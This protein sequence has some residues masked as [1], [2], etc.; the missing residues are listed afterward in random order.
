MYN[1]QSDIYK[2]LRCDVNTEFHEATPYS[3]TYFTHPRRFII[4]K[5]RFEIV[6]SKLDPFTAV[7]SDVMQSR[8]AAHPFHNPQR[9]HEH[10]ECLLGRH[11]CG[12]RV[13]GR[14]ANNLAATVAQRQHPKP[15]EP[16]SGEVNA[17]GTSVGA[18]PALC[19]NGSKE[20]RRQKNLSRAQVDGAS[21]AGDTPGPMDSFCIDAVVTDSVDVSS[22][23]AYVAGSVNVDRSDLDSAK[24]LKV[25]Y[26]DMYGDL[27]PSRGNRPRVKVC[28]ARTPSTK[29]KGPQRQGAKAV[30]KL[31]RT[32]GFGDMTPAE[33]TTYRALSARANDLAQD[34][35]DVAFS[36]K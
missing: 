33:A 31:E 12:S 11:R 10:Y 36:T 7:N 1:D 15:P 18:G 3:E 22:S 23:S 4:T 5:N 30:K 28:A 16:Q 8:R 2:W 34:R 24:V 14:T 6:S 26:E 9:V 35:P 32:S 29:K 25:W 20:D 27:P 17:G 21:A 19:H 13:K